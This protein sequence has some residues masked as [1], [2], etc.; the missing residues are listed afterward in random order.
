MYSLHRD[1]APY[2][3]GKHRIQRGIANG[4]NRLGKKIASLQ[5]QK[6]DPTIH[7]ATHHIADLLMAHLHLVE[8][9]AMEITVIDWET[10]KEVS[11][12]LDPEK[13]PVAYAEAL[14]A[15]ARK[16]RRATEQVTPLIEEATGQLEYL[17]EVECMVGQLRGDEEEDAV[18]LRQTEAEMVAGGYLKMETS[19]VLVEKAAAKARKASKKSGGRNTSGNGTGGSDDYRRY[20]SP[21]GF[22]VL[23]GRNSSQND[24]L[25]MRIAREG[26]VWMHARGVPGAHVLLQVPAGRSPGDDDMQFAA[27]IAAFFSK[28]R[29]EG[30]TDI[31]IAN[32]ADISKPRGAKLGQVMVKKE[33]VMVGRSGNSAAARLE[34]K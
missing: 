6:A 25:T 20:A 28:S 27:D 24:V 13:T 1:L 31:T 30:K 14:Y 3:Q 33:K 17:Q 22:T 18:A 7:A 5:Q 4:I 12:P 23:V 9:G 11:I 8:E 16:Q 32:P 2:L 15:K 10:D 34:E 19:A 26:D 21:G 29:L